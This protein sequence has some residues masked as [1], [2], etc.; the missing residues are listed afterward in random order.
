MTTLPTL[1]PPTL[2]ELR[3]GD[4]KLDPVVQRNF[5]RLH[6]EKIAK[7]FDLN[8]LR[9]FVVSRRPDGDYVIDGQHRRAAALMKAHAG[10]YVPC[11]VY[12]GLD[13]RQEA[14]LFVVSNGMSKRPQPIDLF[15]KRVLAGDS[16]AIE[17]N[18]IV[19]AQGLHLAL[20]GGPATLAA[21]A[22]VERVY[23]RGGAQ[24]LTDTLRALGS[25][26]PGDRET[27]DGTLISAMSVLLEKKG[28][29]LDLQSLAKKL[30]AAGTPIAILGQARN[31]RSALRKSLTSCAVD[32]MVGIYNKGRHTR[33]VVV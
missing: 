14:F 25:A 28:K 21:V 16:D 24:L 23:H 27:W 12:K 31:L 30:S 11:E 9:T 19:E 26:W 10:L 33:K 29:E 7:D 2:E 22:V 3:V 20:G 1:P 4:L 32:V 13:L 8:R 5:D 6:A 15:K 17:I 18:S